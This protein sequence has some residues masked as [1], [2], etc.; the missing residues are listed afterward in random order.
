MREVLAIAPT[1][2]DLAGASLDLWPLS[3]LF[4]RA[5]T[6]NVGISIY[7][8][9]TIEVSPCNRFIIESCDQKQRLSV[10]REELGQGPL[11]L[12][13]SI[14]RA[15]YPSKLPPLKITT[16][17]DSPRGAG[18]GGSSSLAIALLAGIAR[19]RAEF[20]SFSLSEEEMVRIVANIEAQVIKAP[21]GTQ[22]QW[23][24][25]RGQL[26]AICYDS[27]GERVYTS[28]GPLLKALSQRILLC[29]SG[30]SRDSAVNN[31]D[32]YKKIFDAEAEA[33]SQ[34]AAIAKL[35]AMAAQEAIEGQDCSKLLAISR[36]E[37]QHRTKLLPAVQTEKV[38][39]IIRAAEEVGIHLARVCGAGGG[40]AIVFFAEPEKIPSV[41]QAI[42]RAGAEVLDGSVAS[43]GLSVE[44][45]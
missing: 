22:D 41:V 40:G 21:T 5:A 2:V 26:N 45:R 29:F 8:R 43:S 4:A 39:Q 3:Q 44:A 13:G 16:E 9:A 1:R 36:T 18:L 38:R 12:I 42:S 32:L 25:L 11:P 23:G 6:V 37:W 19:M 20:D 30:Q 7:A 10:S 15:I 34:M 35:G 31:W 24:A 14:I 17:C 28:S 33:S 27:N